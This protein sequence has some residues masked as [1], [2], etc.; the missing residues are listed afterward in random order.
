MAPYPCVAVQNVRD[1]PLPSA[2][3]PYFAQPSG[4]SA[5]AMVRLYIFPLHSRTFFLSSTRSGYVFPS[6]TSHPSEPSPLKQSSARTRESCPTGSIGRS[7]RVRSG[8]PHRTLHNVAKGVANAGSSRWDQLLKS[9]IL[10]VPGERIELPTNGLQNRC[11]TAE[12]TRPKLFLLQFSKAPKNKSRS[13]L[14]NCYRMP[15]GRFFRATASASSTSAAASAC[16]F[17]RTCE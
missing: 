7:W 9:L 13:L 4:S 6:T 16:M 17:G 3:Q 15:S 10:L 14:P 8:G 5:D 2:C 11:S 1:V 12:L